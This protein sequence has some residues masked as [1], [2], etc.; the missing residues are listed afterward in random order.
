MLF[1]SSTVHS[2]TPVYKHLH[3]RLHS[4]VNCIVLTDEV[5]NRVCHLV[6]GVNGQ[7]CIAWQERLQ[8][9]LL[10]RSSSAFHVFS[11]VAAA[12]ADDM[13]S[14]WRAIISIYIF[15]YKF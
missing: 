4:Q 7:D 14:R 1:K 6:L 2:V 5:S 10:G 9:V 3:N 11:S 13:V 8:Q 15:N 12:I